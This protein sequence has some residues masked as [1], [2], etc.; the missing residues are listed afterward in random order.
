MCRQG[1]PGRLLRLHLTSERLQRAVLREGIQGGHER[2]PLLASLTLRDD[3]VVA[4]VVHPD[5]ATFKAIKLPGE[6]QERSELR[7]GA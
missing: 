7:P 4:R 5:L 3:V 2:V 6:G 1:R